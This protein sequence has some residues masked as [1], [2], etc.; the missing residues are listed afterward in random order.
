MW[1]SLF[2]KSVRLGGYI[3]YLPVISTYDYVTNICLLLNF[4]IHAEKL[5]ALH[6]VF[7]SV[8]SST[9]IPWHTHPH[10]DHDYNLIWL[11]VPYDTHVLM[12]MPGKLSCNKKKAL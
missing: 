11:S 9:F 8:K 3:P 12:W 1:K 5:L 7:N 10:E 6:S 2:P 4:L